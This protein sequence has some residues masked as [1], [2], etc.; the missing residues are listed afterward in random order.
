[1]MKCSFSL[2]YDDSFFSTLLILG[3]ELYSLSTRN[4][5]LVI[6]G[7]GLQIR[8]LV[9]PVSLSFDNLL[10]LIVIRLDVL[11]KFSKA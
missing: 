6:E 4:L 2:N 11:L 1:M 3:Q 8:R 5:L 7:A 10:N 9:A